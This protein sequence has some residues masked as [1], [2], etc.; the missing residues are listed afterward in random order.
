M[1]SAIVTAIVAAMVLW[2]GS[3][4]AD[5]VERG[6]ILLGSPATDATG[7]VT[8]TYYQQ[9]GSVLPIDGTIITLKTGVRGFSL[10]GDGGTLGFCDLD[11]YFFD[12][13]GARLQYRN[14]GLTQ[15]C[16]EGGEIPVGAVTA[17]VNLY[18]GFSVDYEF[19]AV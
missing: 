17:V 5:Q 1:R 18:F 16:G 9:T 7:G 19:M 12:A 14:T 6:T 15:S 13:N 2:G 10:S 11:M 8:Q 3:A 4:Q